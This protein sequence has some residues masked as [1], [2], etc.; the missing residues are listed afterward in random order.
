MTAGHDELLRLA[1]EILAEH[2]ARTTGNMK[3][4][5]VCKSCGDP[6]PCTTRR[7]VAA[8]KAAILVD[9]QDADRAADEENDNGTSSQ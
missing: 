7:Q 4:G 5:P 9:R 6:H 1:D 3:G 8:A 2:S